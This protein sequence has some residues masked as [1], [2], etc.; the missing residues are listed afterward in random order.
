MTTLPALNDPLVLAGLGGAALVVVLL[1]LVLRAAGRS[2][3]AL[4][5]LVAQLTALG[6]RVQALSDGQHQLAGGLHHV[7][8]AQAASQAR[9]VCIDT[10]AAS[11]SPRSINRLPIPEKRCP[12][13]AA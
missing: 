10:A 7:S 3:R 11:I 6:G 12:A 9:I 8:E 1:L 2:A 5:P 13:F 4:D